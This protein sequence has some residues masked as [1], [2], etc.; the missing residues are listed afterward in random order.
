MGGNF[1][2]WGLMFSV[3]DCT[4]LYLR[5]KVIRPR[6]VSRL[7]QWQTHPT[8][9]STWATALASLSCRCHLTQEPCSCNVIWC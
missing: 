8:L 4:F 1:A 9:S 2:N 6:P 7:T 5:Q 3:F